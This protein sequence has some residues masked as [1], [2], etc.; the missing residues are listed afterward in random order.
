MA[1]SRPRIAMTG[2]GVLGPGC[3]A[4]VTAASGIQR[5][6]GGDFKV[7]CVAGGVGDILVKF[8]IAWN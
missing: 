4:K 1:S 7:V 6:S 5:G 2:L 3:A 8:E